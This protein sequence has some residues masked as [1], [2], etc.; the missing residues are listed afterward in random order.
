MDGVIIVTAR[1]AYYFPD[2][3]KHTWLV[4]NNRNATRE[5]N[6]GRDKIMVA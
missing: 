5:F 3:V 6:E 4:V 1:N 2:I